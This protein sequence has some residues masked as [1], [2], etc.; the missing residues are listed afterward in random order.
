PAAPAW[1]WA[2]WAVVPVLLVALL[3]TRRG[4]FEWPVMRFSPIYNGVVPAAVIAATLGWSL[5]ACTRAGAAAP[6]LY[7]PLLNPLELAQGFVLLNAAAWWKATG[8]RM[9]LDDNMRSAG[10]ALGAFVGFV[11]LN[12]VIARVVH[13]YLGVPFEFQRLLDSPIFQT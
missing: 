10:R 5:W 3:R 6:L 7:I 11:A 9:A 2:V 13:F 1:S 12:A 4:A 8:R